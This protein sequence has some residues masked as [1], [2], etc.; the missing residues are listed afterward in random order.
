MKRRPAVPHRTKDLMAEVQMR[1]TIRRMLAQGGVVT[2]IG[3]NAC[4]RI[5]S[6]GFGTFPAELVEAVMAGRD[7]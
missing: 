5:P 2:S 3:P 1:V 4:I 6:G 7:E